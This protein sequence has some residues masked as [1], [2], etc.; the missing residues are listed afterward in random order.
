MTS[1]RH[2]AS[3]NPYAQSA[4]RR[5]AVRVAVT[6]AT[7]LERPADGTLSSPGKG[8]ATFHVA[9]IAGEYL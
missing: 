5:S 2:D 6:T 9:Q 7:G 4:Q 8:N 1:S 3:C